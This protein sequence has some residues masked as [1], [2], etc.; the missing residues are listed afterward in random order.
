MGIKRFYIKEILIVLFLAVLLVFPIFFS[1]S[2]VHEIGHKRTAKSYGV[3][4]DIGWKRV[5]PST[6]NDCFSFNSLD[7]EAKIDILHAGVFYEAV[8]LCFLLIVFLGIIL[9]L[10]KT[11]RYK[12]ILI[13]AVSV[14]V[15][16]ILLNVLLK[17][18]YTTNPVADWNFTGFS[19]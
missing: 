6:I 9:C 16:S 3:S 13:T 11:K 5:T 8:F 17:N 19:C 2:Y 7:E 14:V 15:F 4:F 10:I 18:V 1:S 12:L